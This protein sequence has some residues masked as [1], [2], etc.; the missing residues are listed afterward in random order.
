M[1]EVP[2]FRLR[3]TC[4]MSATGRATLFARSHHPSTPSSCSQRS[5]LAKLKHSLIPPHIGNFMQT[6]FCFAYLEINAKGHPQKTYP[7]MYPHPIWHR[8]TVSCVFV[9]CKTFRHMP[10]LPP[11]RLEKTKATGCF[12]HALESAMNPAWVCVKVFS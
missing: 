3:R 7:L 6:S 1:G 4:S 9:F 12:A 2:Y 11:E 8:T 5:P 10:L